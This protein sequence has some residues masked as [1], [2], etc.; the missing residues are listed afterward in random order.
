MGKKILVLFL[1]W[2]AVLILGGCGFVHIE[3]EEKTPLDYTV[4]KAEEIPKEVLSLI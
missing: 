4:L 1:V 3:E 2:A